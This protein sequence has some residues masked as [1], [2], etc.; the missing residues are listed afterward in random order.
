M[1]LFDFESC[2]DSSLIRQHIDVSAS[3][4]DDERAMTI[5]EL[6][7]LGKNQLMR[8]LKTV[9]DNKEK[10][11]GINPR[12]VYVFDFNSKSMEAEIYSLPRNIKKLR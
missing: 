11:D 6:N 12:Y 5:E 8:K 9:A 2:K 4:L 1:K 7:K 3:S 10:I